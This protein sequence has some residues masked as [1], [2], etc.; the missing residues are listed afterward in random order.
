MAFHLGS[1]KLIK[2]TGE[3]RRKLE[4]NKENIVIIEAANMQI[5]PICYE[6]RN[7]L[8]RSVKVLYSFP[9]QCATAALFDVVGMIRYFDLKRYL[10]DETC[11]SD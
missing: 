6:D 3:D 4:K 8:K 2:L 5:T 7:L 11:C 9:G 1:R 10:M